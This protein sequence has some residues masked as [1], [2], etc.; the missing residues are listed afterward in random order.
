MTDRLQAV[1]AREF[2]LALERRVEREFEAARV[3]AGGVCDGAAP[4][5]GH[6]YNPNAS[7]EENA[8]HVKSAVRA[9]LARRWWAEEAAPRWAMSVT[10]PL[11]SDDMR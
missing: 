8:P 2:E 3:R 10:L 1:S 7:R 5:T 9:L 4:I 11:T 6:P